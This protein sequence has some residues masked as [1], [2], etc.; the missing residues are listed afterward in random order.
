VLTRSGEPADLLRA[1]PAQPLVHGQS[2]AAPP[3][4]TP[5]SL[6]HPWT[7]QLWRRRRERADGD[8]LSERSS[9]RRLGSARTAKHRRQTSF[10]HRVAM[11]CPRSA[12]SPRRGPTRKVETCSGTSLE[13]SSQEHPARS[14]SWLA[15]ASASL[16]SRLVAGACHVC[17][18][19]TRDLRSSCDAA[20]AAARSHS[21]MYRRY[22]MGAALPTSAE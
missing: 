12:H 7:Q 6:L 17:A 16:A 19:C 13:R 20:F 14:P 2:T 18:S 10:R 1:L 4:R 3:A 22:S 9:R 5:P 21:S 15:F 8:V 11:S